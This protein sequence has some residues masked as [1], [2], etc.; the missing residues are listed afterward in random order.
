MQPEEKS[1]SPVSYSYWAEIWAEIRELDLFVFSFPGL[2][3]ETQSDSISP[4]STEFSFEDH[5]WARLGW[6]KLSTL[7]KMMAMKCGEVSKRG[8][9]T[10]TG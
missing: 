9:G 2:E 1:P 10:V 8:R 5:W 6:K 3:Q 7:R 4:L